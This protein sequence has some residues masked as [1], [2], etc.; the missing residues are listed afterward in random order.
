MEW[1]EGEW[2]GYCSW[3]AECSL[4]EEVECRDEEVEEDRE[5]FLLEEKRK[6]KEQRSL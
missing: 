6:S 4:E 3:R 2:E 5:A 1:R